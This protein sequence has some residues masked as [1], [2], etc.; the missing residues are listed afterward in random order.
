MATEFQPT[1]FVFGDR[2][3][4]GLWEIGHY[5]QHRRYV[6]YL[7]GQGVLIADHPIIWMGKNKFQNQVWLQDH[8]ALH[9][10]LRIYANVTGVD[11]SA[12][13][14]TNRNEFTTWL[15]AHATEHNDI[16]TAFK[17]T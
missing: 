4:Q 13:D 16:D 6:D 5:R 8:A 7:A 12:V 10:Q 11:L 17:L 1:S 9:N 3:G 15:D 2:A 14:L